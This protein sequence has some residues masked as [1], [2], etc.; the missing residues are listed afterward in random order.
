MSEITLSDLPEDHELRNRPLV[1]MYYYSKG[2]M[3]K[4]EVRP[5]Y[6]IA[7][8]C[9]NDLGETWTNTERFVYVEADH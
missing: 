6:A 4:A 7:K 5:A 1:G 9:Y 3:I 2:S 8:V